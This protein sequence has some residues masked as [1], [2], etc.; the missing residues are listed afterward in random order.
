[1]PKCAELTR[2]SLENTKAD[3]IINNSII[4]LGTFDKYTRVM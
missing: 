4:T 3:G 1:M 2:K